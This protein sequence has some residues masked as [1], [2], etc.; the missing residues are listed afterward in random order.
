[1]STSADSSGST[2]RAAYTGSFAHYRDLPPAK[3]PEYCVL[4]RSNVGKSSFLNRIFGEK[5]IAKISKRP[6]KTVCANLFPVDNGLTFVDLPGYGYAKIGDDETRRIGRLIQE[7]CEKR[8][9]LRGI[10]W[11]LDIRHPGLEADR[12]AFDWLKTLK[13]PLLAVLTK[14]DKVG[15]SEAT[16][17]IAEY[18]NLFELQHKPLVFS[19]ERGEDRELFWHEF[20]TWVAGQKQV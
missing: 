6:G 14:A 10:L 2:P 1:M 15:R 17:H 16:R 9:Y 7:Y 18:R 8:E 12:A 20:D 19:A 4:G 3:G 5:K 13:V 11:L